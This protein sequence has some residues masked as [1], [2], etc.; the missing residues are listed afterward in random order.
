MARILDTDYMEQYRLALKAVIQHSG[1]AYA[2]NYARAGYGMTAG[3]EVHAQCLYVL[4]NLAQWRGKEA[5][6]AKEILQDIA[7]RSERC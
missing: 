1:N 6:A 5:R 7:R 4:S 2:I 3:H